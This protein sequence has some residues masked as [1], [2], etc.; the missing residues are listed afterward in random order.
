MMKLVKQHTWQLLMLSMAALL[1][2]VACGDD[3]SDPAP[4]TAPTIEPTAIVQGMTASPT[5]GGPTATPSATFRPTLTL[6]PP[7]NTA[8]ANPTQLPSNTPEP[9]QYQ[10]QAGDTCLQIA[11]NYDVSVEA[12][13]QAN[14]LSSCRLISEG[15]VLVVPRPTLTP[16]PFGLELTA[17]AFYER[18][19]PGMRNV[20][21]YALYEYCPEE[22]DTLTSI[23]LTFGTTN[24]RICELNPLPDGLDCRGCDFSQSAVGSC[25]NPPQISVNRCYSVPGPTYTPTATETPF[26]E[27]SITPTPTHLPPQ[28]FYPSN[29]QQIASTTLRLLWTHNSGQLQA[30]EHYQIIVMDESSGE[31]LLSR[32]TTQTDLLLPASLAPAAGQQRNLSWSVQVVRIEN[33]LPVPLSGQSTTQGFVW[34]P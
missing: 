31:I 28:P 7:T 11:L 8:A 22:G 27:P 18:L 9:W 29:G 34:A 1:L 19:A 14:N 32:E 15:Q 20:T 25:P 10:V 24:Q 16:T 2:L 23:A 3:D 26:G 21:P 12:I 13:E 33:D 6:A 4:T 30:N 5:P 17:T